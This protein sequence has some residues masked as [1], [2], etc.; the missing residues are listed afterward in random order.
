MPNN[1]ATIG[2]YRCGRG[3]PLLVIAGP[4]VIESEELTL[5]IAAR[6]KQIAANLPVQLV[7][8][9]SFD[10]ANRT[11]AAAFRGQGWKRDWRFLSSVKAETGLPV[12]TDI[13]DRI[14]SS[15]GGRSVRPAANSRF[16]LPANR[17][18]RG[19]GKNRPG[20]EREERAIRGP[21]GYEARRRQAGGGRLREYLAVR[22]R[23]VFRLRPAGERHAGDSARCSRWACR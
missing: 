14:S 8:K 16:P 2:P 9:A 12:T 23:H 13:H 6:L 19:R 20:G 15:N 1:P 10:K 4:C 22:A 5:S 3:Q 21:L 11:S 18:A 7:F 17:F